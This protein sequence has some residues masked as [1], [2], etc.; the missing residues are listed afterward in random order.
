MQNTQVYCENAT[1]FILFKS[2]S[3]R[4]E[5]IALSKSDVDVG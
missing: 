3:E 5:V 4:K 1:N 2:E